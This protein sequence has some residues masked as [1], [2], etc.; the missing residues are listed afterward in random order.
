MSRQPSAIGAGDRV[1]V[2]PVKIARDEGA[3]I[4]ISAGVLPTDRV[5]DS[6]PDSIRSGDKVRVQKAAANAR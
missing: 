4:L 1:T 5:I 3:S 6:P 2:K